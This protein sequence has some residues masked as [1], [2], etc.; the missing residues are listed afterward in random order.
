[1]TNDTTEFG[2]PALAR[3]SSQLVPCTEQHAR[4]FMVIED[5]Q[6][7]KGECLGNDTWSEAMSVF[8]VNSGVGKIN[9]NSGEVYIRQNSIVQLPT[10]KLRS[11]SW[12]GASFSVSGISF[13]GDF[14]AEMRIATKVLPGT[15]VFPSQRSFRSW[16]MSAREYDRMRRQIGLL[17]DYSRGLDDPYGKQILAHAFV[18]F[19]LDMESL[20]LKGSGPADRP[21]SR[22][23]LYVQQFIK[24]VQQQFREDRVIKDYADQ[25]NVSAKYLTQLVKQY[26]GKNASELI[27]EQVIREAKV[28]LSDPQLSIGEIAGRLYFSDQ[29]F[30]GKYFKRQTGISPK[31]YRMDIFRDGRRARPYVGELTT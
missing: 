8:I 31:R 24:L 28:L 14:I 18:A 17:A 13:T 3:H 9:F 22:Q 12:E 5:L 30:F 25:L 10:D 4:N 15:P 2:L 21:A 29:S 1:M 7:T 27:T 19:L 6:L 16:E 26:T 23:E 20:G 11:V